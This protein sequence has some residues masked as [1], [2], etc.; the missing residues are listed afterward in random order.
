[1]AITKIQSESLNLSDNYDFTGTVTG[2]GGTT[3]P[4]FNV[5]LSSAPAISHGTT[6]KINFNSVVTESSSGVFD[7]TNYKFTVATAG[8]YQITLKARAID[9][10]NNLKRVDLYI[11]K[12]GSSLGQ[13]GGSSFETDQDYNGFDSCCSVILDLAVSDYIEGYIYGETS[14]S[15][16]FLLY[17]E[18]GGIQTYLTGFKMT[19]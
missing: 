17:G 7:T 19:E 18:S 16:T 3:A 9:T 11:Y 5:K 14:D 13:F 2:A 6:S 1:M 4:Y 10:E 8:K 15:G 12:N